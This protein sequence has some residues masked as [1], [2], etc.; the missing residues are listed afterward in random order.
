MSTT[1]EDGARTAPV[2]LLEAGYALAGALSVLAALKARGLTADERLDLLGQLHR[3][4][5]ALHGHFLEVL[6]VAELF[7]DAKVL[8]HGT[9]AAI[10][11][12]RLRFAPVIARQAVREARTLREHPST[13]SALREGTISGSHVTQIVTGLRAIEPA[14]LRQADH[15]ESMPP[16][17]GSSPGRSQ[18]TAQVEGATRSST[19]QAE[20]ILLDLSESASPKEVRLAA[21]HLRHTIDPGCAEREFT[22]AQDHSTCHLSQTLDG[23]WRLEAI[24]DPE[25]GGLIQC[26]ISALVGEQLRGGRRGGRPAGDEI[27]GS[28]TDPAAAADPV[29]ASSEIGATS[30]PASH[31]PT[32]PT[33][34]GTE[35][36]C[37]E[38]DEPDVESHGDESCDRGRRRP[39]QV[40]MGRRRAQALTQL[41]VY[42]LDSGSL[43]HHG[44]ERP[45]LTV[46][47]P[48]EVL[49]GLPGAG[50]TEWGDAL[51]PSSIRRLA[52]DARVTR[53]VLDPASQPLDVGRTRRLATIAQRRALEVRDGGCRFAG[54]DRP[55][56]WCDAHHVIPWL[57]GGATD[58]DN[59]VLLCRAH[60][61]LVHRNG[62][63]GLRL[64]PPREGN[65]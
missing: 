23:R 29:P 3:A 5:N 32:E 57:E 15:P 36:D 24:L 35:P 55:P 34:T 26:A 46:T 53:V 56:G 45:H 22:R 9:P 12:N 19:T 11:S 58:L 27:G 48:L 65:S 62:S 49:L 7:Q 6:G 60:H 33:E 40:P 1:I 47:V 4:G 44:G 51:P 52:C 30:S 25:S 43:D 64:R 17:E 10:L 14:L 20:Q 8:G 41:A 37:S 50:M 42:L 16:T 21:Q 18:T 31:E 59:L 63:A 2:T 38:S 28:P 13:L 39:P 61:T 54:C